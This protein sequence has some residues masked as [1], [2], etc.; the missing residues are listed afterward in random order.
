MYVVGKVGV[1]SLDL[2]TERRRDQVLSEATYI[3]FQAWLDKHH[4][5]DHVIVISSI[6]AIY[7]NFATLEAA[8]NVTGGEIQ[9]DLLDHWR[10]AEH[11]K[12]RKK[13]FQLLFNYAHAAKTRVTIISGD[14]HI[15]ALGCIQHS[16]FLKESN[17][18]CINS[19]ITSAVVNCPPPTFAVSALKL[20][21]G[22]EDKVSSKMKAGLCKFPPQKKTY[23]IGHRNFLSCVTGDDRS[24][25]CKWFAETKESRKYELHI[26]GWGKKLPA[27][28]HLVFEGVI[29]ASV[30]LLASA[31][32]KGL[33]NIFQ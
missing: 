15:G 11:Q 14:V 30:N 17:A 4:G 9:D 28:Q 32:G 7:N 29:S 22:E 27:D 24:I 2:R 5:L 31:G 20:N 33:K 26:A 16:K 23:Y 25:F 19:L 6:P 8:V 3:C 1:A 13:F 18:G 12:E 10:A 21:A